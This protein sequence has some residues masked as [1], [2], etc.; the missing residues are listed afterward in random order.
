MV[1]FLFNNKGEN[2]MQKRIVFIIMA[3]MIAMAGGAHAAKVCVSEDKFEKMIRNAVGL[4]YYCSNSS[5]SRT[6]RGSY[7]W[8]MS[9]SGSWSY[10][11]YNDSNSS[12]CATGCPSKCG[13]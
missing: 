1:V 7:C 10:S 5:S 6:G 13:V 4:N 11:G 9:S 3:A 2:T 12:Y 8:C